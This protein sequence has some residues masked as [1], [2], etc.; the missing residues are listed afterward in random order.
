MFAK[1]EASINLKGGEKTKSSPIDYGE[2]RRPH[3][4]GFPSCRGEK[5]KK[6]ERGFSVFLN[7]KRK[8]GGG[9]AFLVNDGGPTNCPGKKKKG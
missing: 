5:K 7:G 3:G 1:T 8:K 9:R 2:K 6:A 4:Q